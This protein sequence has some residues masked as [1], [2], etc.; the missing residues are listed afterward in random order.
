M[1]ITLALMRWLTEYLAVVRL[2]ALIVQKARQVR[3]QEV[4]LKDAIEGQKDKDKASEA[5]V[6]VGKTPSASPTSMEIQGPHKLAKT[7]NAPILLYVGL[8]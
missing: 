7:I 1:G 5:L 8:I 2:H 4:V 3:A 6:R